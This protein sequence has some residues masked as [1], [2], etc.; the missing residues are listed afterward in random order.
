MEQ[1][2]NENRKEKKIEWQFCTIC[3]ASFES[4]YKLIKHMNLSHPEA[5]KDGCCS[6]GEHHE[7]SGRIS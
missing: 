5:L 1:L 7:Q 6:G 3:G 4:E 2:D